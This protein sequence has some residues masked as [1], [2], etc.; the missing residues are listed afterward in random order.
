MGS[1]TSIIWGIVFS[2]I[3]FAYFIYGR[4]QKMGVPLICGASLMVFPY[5]ISN[6]ILLVFVGCVLL[7]V[8]YFIRY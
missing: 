4:K 1:E 3:G 2:A 8:P 7:A 6:A 5:F